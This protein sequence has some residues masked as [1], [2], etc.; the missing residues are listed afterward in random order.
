[1]SRVSR[2]AKRGSNRMGSALLLAVLA[3]FGGMASA[4]AASSPLS[5]AVAEGKHIFIHDTFGGSHNMTCESCHKAA[6]MG[7]TVT[8][9]G[10][11]FPS[12]ANAATIFPRY[13]KHAGR[14]ITLEDQI[15]GCVARGMGGKPPAYGSKTMNALVAYLT[16]LSKGKPMNM[17]GKPK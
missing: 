11:H 14:V 8:P 2:N 4:H 17:G 1:M 3:G 7:Q 9:N 15:R 12:L 10:H 16:S 6:G 5:Q 13:N